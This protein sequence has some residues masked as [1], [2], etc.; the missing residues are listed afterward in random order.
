MGGESQMGDDNQL[1]VPDKLQ[2]GR[3]AA[4]TSKLR[5]A[6]SEIQWRETIISLTARIYHWKT[7]TDLSASEGG[8]EE[9]TSLFSN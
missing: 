4:G 7:E 5:R 9:I 6:E 8:S 2:G 3:K 1:A